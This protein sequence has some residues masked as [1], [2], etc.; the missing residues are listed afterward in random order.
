MNSY[1]GWDY[2]LIDIA[3][4]FGKDKLTFEDRIKWTTDNFKEL[5]N[6][7]PQA[8]NY[9]LYMKGVMSLRKVHAGQPTGHM[10]AF[11]AVCSGLQIMSVLTGC[12]KGATATGL[13]DPNRR[14]DAYS[15]LAK[16]MQAILGPSFHVERKP[17][18][19]ALM[20]VL[21]GSKD[22]PKKIFGKDTPEL[23]AFY[24]AVVDMAPGAWGLLQDLLASW[25]PGALSHRW[26][27]PDG[28][29]A[30]V[31]VMVDKEMR[32][33]IEEL[34]NCSFTYVYYENE[35]TKKGLSNAANVVHSIDAYILR[36]V[37]RR[38]NYDEEMV[39]A[40]R[41]GIYGELEAR[42]QGGMQYIPDSLNKG[43]LTY[44]K[45]Y[46]RSGIADIVILPHLA[47]SMQYCVL[48]TK[49]LEGLLAIIETMVVHNPFEVV[50]VHDSFACHPNNMNHLRQHYINVLAELA[51][52]DLLSDIL[53]QIH[54][55]KGT[56][57]KLSTNLSTLI[58]A[59]NYALS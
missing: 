39:H 48:D 35:G 53:S 29:D 52:S 46:M 55:K 27:L 7:A 5:E 47:S 50:T 40:A 23:N 19:E 34:A 11:D 51:D 1:T 44:Q 24:E 6:L 32:P 31:K 21:Y 38:S 22:Q 41:R 25:Q 20:T 57:R 17:A 45:H 2:M 58:R 49:H 42:K 12:F 13:V 18:K 4:Q 30:R 8:E 3:N 9:P 56:F 10:V 37:H 16:H 26:T 59:S 36:C 33:K 14:A 15:D 28:F 54:G 43:V